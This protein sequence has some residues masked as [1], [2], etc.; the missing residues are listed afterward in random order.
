MTP[1]SEQPGSPPARSRGSMASRVSLLLGDRR[2]SVL[3]LSLSSIVAG[4][5][6]A[7][8]LAL[9]AA[10][11]ATL[12][13]GAKH[14]HTHIG[15][16]YVHA[17]LGKLIGIAFLLTL[18]RIALQI[19]LSVL[20]ARITTEVQAT[21]RRKLFEAYTDASW[22]VQ[23]QDREGQL[24]E[25]MTG[26]VM[27]ATAGAQQATILINALFTFLV[28]MISAVVLSPFAALVVGAASLLLFGALRPLRARGVHYSRGLSK[29]QVEYAGAIAESIRLAEETH[30]FGVVAPQRER[31]ERYVEQSKHY[32]YSTQLLLRLVSNL[33]QSVIVLLLV[34]GI[35]GLYFIAGP[36]HAGSLGGV[37]LVLARAGISG[38]ILQGAYQGL[39]QS[40]PFIERTQEAIERYA[41]SRVRDGGQPLAQREHPGLR[42]RLLRISRRRSPCSPTSASRSRQAR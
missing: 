21:T 19:P 8:T 41:G 11:A 24:Q 33:Y 4:F 31:I 32:L 23:S 9:L 18:L 5:T 10:I 40:L 35:A 42:E 15:P 13:T 37:V 29:A 39:A 36:G 30:V 14:L 26:Q 1:D 12:V 3:A 22:G 38:Q 6:E 25:T 27:Q 34:L 17:S 2:R 20:P 7:G 16:F 28:L